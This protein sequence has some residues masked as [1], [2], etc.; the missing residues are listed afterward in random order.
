MHQKKRNAGKHDQRRSRDIER[1][2][3]PLE[4]WAQAGW[5]KG[6][7]GPPLDF[8]CPSFNAAIV[9]YIKENV[10]NQSLH[11]FKMI[12]QNNLLVQITQKM[13]LK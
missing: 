11:S 8:Q 1:D 2:S 13:T 6:V 3:L 10:I 9:Q 12:G 4:A 5:G 7:L